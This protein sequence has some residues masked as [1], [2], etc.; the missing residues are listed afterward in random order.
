M[1]PP[2]FPFSALIG[3][4]PLRLA[5]MLAAVDWRL[6]VLIMGEKGCGKSTAARALARLLPGAAPFVEVPVGTTE[7]RLLGGIDLDAAFA[8]E[9]RLQRGLVQCAH[10]GVLYIDEVNLLPDQMTDALLDALATGYYRLERDG[11][12][13]GASAEFILLGTMN[14][15]EGSLRPQLLD[16]FALSVEVLPPAEPDLRVRIVKTREEFD[17]NPAEFCTR[18]APQDEALREQ[19]A[20]ARLRL[21]RVRIGDEVLRNIAGMVAEHGVLSLRADLALYRA[22]RALAAL[23]GREEALPE[24]AERV[25]P[26]VLLHRHRT[27]SP[28]Q[29]PPSMHPDQASSG[30]RDGSQ[31]G[32]ERVFL[33]DPVA[34]PR[35]RAIG[36][37]GGR[38]ARAPGWLQRAP[39]GRQSKA[40]AEPP[41]LD[42]FA[43]LRKAVVSTAQPQLDRNH[44]VGRSRVAADPEC[45]LFAVDTS[46][47]LAARRRIGI[48]KGLVIGLLERFHTEG[49][50]VGV[51]GFR[52]GSAELLLP[53]CREIE[54]ARQLLS[55]IPSGGRTPLAHAL[56]MAAGFP[57]ERLCF[58]LFSDG[59]ANVGISGGDPWQEALEWAAR[60]RCPAL[61]VD[62]AAAGNPRLAE[63]ARV[64]GAQL[65]QLEQCCEDTV[66]QLTTRRRVTPPA[67]E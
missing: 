10:G 21:P 2:V 19:I 41:P 47:S 31:S 1:T 55:Y 49:R 33:P 18:F 45:F 11:F 35:I 67:G 66:L 17:A 46:G 60:I 40:A 12:S 5:L 13:T 28:R 22:C 56:Q 24:D 29:P 54:R 43:S 44:V 39:E 6:G 15:E 8:G 3:L 57:Q 65:L 30:T 27:T 23:E 51:I 16:R 42:V 32:Q 48:V 63:L 25:A 58:I 53:P 20:Q 61:V 38:S 26:F 34:A 59:Q 36:G 7:E 62:C 14:P 9:A 64:M 50:Q 52:G 37:A 4:E